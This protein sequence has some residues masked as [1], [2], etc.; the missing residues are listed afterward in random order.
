MQRLSVIIIWLL[1]P[2]YLVAQNHSD[3]KGINTEVWEKF[4][5]AYKTKDV[6]L[7]SSIHHEDFIRINANSKS[8]KDKTS[9]IQDYKKNWNSKDNRKLKIEFRFLE[10]ILSS[11]KA[12]ERGI[13]K[14]SI[15]PDTVEERSFYGKFHVILIK[16]GTWKLLVDYDS[17][18]NG[19]I[20][21]KDYLTANDINAY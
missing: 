12:S 1:L 15:N 9:Y 11:N 2:F 21:E 16:N 3:F 14:L 4:S 18:E 17:D 13:Y 8:I 10:R 20:G 7:Y 6:A 5:Q 19:T